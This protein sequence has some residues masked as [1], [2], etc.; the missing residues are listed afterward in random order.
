M[1]VPHAILRVTV[2]LGNLQAEA[3]R[4]RYGALAGWLEARDLAALATAHH[5]DDQVETLVMRLN[6]GSGVGGLAAI[7]GRGRVPGSDLTLLRPVLGFRRDEL[8]EVVRSAGLV[9]AQDPS[10]HSP[11]FDR[12]RLRGHLAAAEWLDHGAIARSAACLADADAALDWTAE[13]LWVEQVGIGP[14]QLSLPVD[15]PKALS[16]RLLARAFA[17]FALPLP[18]GSDLARMHDRLAA[19]EAA[20]L[21]GLQ[22]RSRRGLWLVQREEARQG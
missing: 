3:R 22:A 11:K 21:G 17:H 1:Q 16:L 12:V 7:R 14:D 6:R 8:G 13:R 4:A 15:L 9:A 10:N 5:L 18:R 2:G 20:T 19:G